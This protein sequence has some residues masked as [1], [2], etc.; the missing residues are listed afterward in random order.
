[1][2]ISKNTPFTEENFQKVLDVVVSLQEAVVNL[3]KENTELRQKVKGLEL[4][5]SK[6]SHNSSKPPSSD[7][8][9]KKPIVNQRTKTGKSIGGQ[10]GHKS[11]S[12]PFYEY[13]DKVYYHLPNGC[14]CGA[15]HWDEKP[16]EIFQVVDLPP[17]KAYVT[18]HRK[19]KYRCRKCGME[20]S[21]EP[22]EGK[23]NKIQYGTKLRSLAAYLNQ[24]QLIPYH[25]LKEMFKDLLSIDLSVGSLVNFVKETGEGLTA[26]EKHVNRCL[27]HA[28]VLHSDETG[29]RIEGKTN[30]I[31]VVSNQRY[32][33]LHANKSRG[34]HAIEQMDIL[35]D[36]TGVLVHDRFRSYFG[37]WTFSHSLCNAHILRELI[38]FEEQGDY[39]WATE[40]K[41]LLL[42]AK[43]KKDNGLAITN[44]Y[45]TR[46][47]NKYRKIVRG[48]LQKEKYKEQL[49]NGKGRPKRSEDHNFL[50]AL[51]KYWKEI[52]LFIR[53]ENVPFD[54]NQAERDLR[55]VKIK[56]KVSGCFRSTSGAKSFAII[57]S[58]L[59][60]L[61]KNNLPVLNGMNNI[62]QNVQ[63]TAISVE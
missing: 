6:D 9:K 61:R 49:P 11:N 62:F 52:L 4:R 21:G 14:D 36:F 47:G 59:S 45:N 53:E 15:E 1:M 46:V 22:P 10:P 60:T 17:I 7:G 23:G 41:K 29:I 25:R 35:P 54:N 18:E 8:Y 37:D 57:R 48:E 20:F 38:Y 39:P 51:N 19:I 2:D 56:Q 30:W 26:F 31:H 5:L 3:T 12:K 40:I 50:I 44:H 63:A 55:M 34:R 33:Y 13:P 43:E 24:Y 16:I 32:T 58:Y 27:K 42:K 28:E